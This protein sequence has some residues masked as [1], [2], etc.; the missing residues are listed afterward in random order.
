MDVHLPLSATIKV[1][2]MEH[3]KK[4]ITMGFAL[5]LCAMVALVGVGYALAY[6]GSAIIDNDDTN[7]ETITVALGDGEYVNFL[8]GQYTL[9]TSNNGT[10]VTLNGLKNGNTVIN[11]N[12]L[13]TAKKFHYDADEV[14][15]FVLNTTDWADETHYSAY[16]VGSVTATIKQT[17]GA[18][19]TNVVLGMTGGP[20]SAVNQ[21]GFSLVY[22]IGDD[23]YATV[24]NVPVTLN[25]GEASVTITA[26][27]VYSE[28]VPTG[29]I[30]SISAYTMTAGNI[31]ITASA[32]TPVSP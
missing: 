15:K 19:A 16:E 29:S 30:E 4:K 26:Y 18:T 31:E 24:S 27:L 23:V 6:Q 32:S 1:V 10:T 7:S 8:E 17:A 21:Y 13:Y 25:N 11:D 2:N 5:L 22:V 28:T 12:E 20:A 9:N 3:K 14:S